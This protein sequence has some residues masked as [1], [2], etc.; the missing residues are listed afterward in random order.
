MTIAMKVIDPSKE[1][2]AAVLA[3]GH[4]PII[5]PLNNY[6]MSIN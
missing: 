3:N 2:S 5:L 4:V 6:I 1:V